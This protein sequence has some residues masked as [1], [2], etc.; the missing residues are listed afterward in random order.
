MLFKVGD[1]VKIRS[2][3]VANK[4]LSGVYINTNMR[5]YGGVITKIF[6]IRYSLYHV[7]E[8][9]ILEDNFWRWPEE[10]LIPLFD[11]LDRATE[12]TG[13]KF[14]LKSGR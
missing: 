7:K 2:D 4:N 8:V 1:K 10:A 13:Y 12:I 11:C 5:D 9:V 3:L 14:Q 6:D